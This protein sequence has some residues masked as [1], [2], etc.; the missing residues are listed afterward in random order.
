MKNFV[1]VVSICLWSF[2]LSAEN[3]G[4]DISYAQYQTDNQQSYLELYFAVQGHT[5]SYVRDKDGLFYG[6]VE[7]TVTF[8]QDSL[9]RSADKFRI[10]SPAQKDTS[11]ISGVFIQQERFM[12]P[13]GEYTMRLQ[14]VNINDTAESYDISQNVEIELKE[15]QTAASDLLFLDSYKPASS[16][17]KYAKSGYELI[18]MVSSGNYFFPQSVENI[19][20]YVELYNINEQI[21][22]KTPYLLKYYI[23]N[24]DT[25]NPLNQFAS[26]SKKEAVAVQPVLAG[27]NIAKLPTGNYNMV[28]QA[29]DREGNTILEKKEFFFRRNDAAQ[30]SPSEN[31]VADVSGTF[32][33][34]ITSFDSLYLY[35]KYLDPI[36]GDKER[37]FQ[38]SLL[39]QQDMKQMKNYF[40]TFWRNVNENDPG[41]EWQKYHK[42]VKI[43]NELYD[44]RLERGYMSSRGRIYLKY[45]R[46]YLVEDRKFEPSLPPYEIWQYNQV[47]SPYVV[48]QTNKIFI[49]A[50]FE[51][52]TNDYRLIHSTA[53]GELYNRRWQYD[54]AQ[55][56]YGAGGNI[57]QNNINSGDD[58]GSRLNNNIILQSGSKSENMR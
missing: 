14:L 19:S 4:L 54:L 17:N 32:V 8:K 21:G 49:F 9:I 31:I 26:L 22:H 41:G 45:G 38:K 6:G 20:F 46:P 35:I 18:P 37:N 39:T 7:V 51:S 48:K 52:S 15:D 13:A 27:F 34:R 5:L 53:I 40:Y 24:A 47:N 50:N 25:E 55:G 12:L 10:L 42:E 56:V 30:V 33:D 23:E 28:I 11:S 3:L 57:D 2:F 58:F 1:F 44:T 36:S 16:D 29:A 43:A